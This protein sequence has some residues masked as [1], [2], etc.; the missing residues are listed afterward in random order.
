M[1]REQSS[2]TLED[3]TKYLKIMIRLLIEEQITAKKMNMGN[4]ILLLEITQIIGWSRGATSSVLSKMK[5]RAK[6]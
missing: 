5:K 6:G 4:A 1:R 2:A 3:D